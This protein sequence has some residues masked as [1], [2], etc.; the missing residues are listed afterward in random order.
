MT[1]LTPEQRAAAFAEDEAIAVIAGAGT[2][3]TRV[4][5]ERYLHLAVDRGVEL[6]RILTVTF[7]EKAAREMKDRIRAALVERGRTD[8]A[9]RAEFAPISTIHAFLSRVLRERALDAGIDPRA[10][11]ADEITADFFLDEAMAATVDGLDEDL[12][13]D[14]VE[15]TGSEE[16][17]RTLYLAARATPFEMAELRP[18]EPVREDLRARVAA[19]LDG[20]A[21]RTHPGATGGRLDGLHALRPRLLE[22]D[23]SAA[24]EFS[25][26]VKGR[27]ANAVRALF[28]DG[29]E[30]AE[31]YAGLAHADRA[32]RAGRAIREALCRLDAE[33]AER[34]WAEGIVD[35]ADLER[36]GLKLLRSP[37]AP[38]ILAEYDHLLVDEYQDTS[39][40]QEA[41]LE[42]LAK[43]C[44][45]FGVGDAKQSIY[46]FR[47][48]DAA[49]FTA[50]QERAR[51][52]PLAGSF[53][54]RPELVEFAN[55]LFEQLFLGSGVESQD[56][57][58]AAEWR[59][60][61]APCV[62][63]LTFP[64]D[65]A[66]QGRRREARALARR[67]RELVGERELE[68]TS[69]RDP[70]RP[71]GYRDCAILLRTMSNL[72]VY[73]RALAEEGV[74]YVVVKGRGYYAAREVVDLAH[75]L[76]ALA[77]PSDRYRA[78]GAMTSLLCG[79]PESDLLQLPE[80]GP[81][82]LAVRKTERPSAIPA[83]R[84]RRLQRFADQFERWRRRMGEVET[85][86]LIETILAE[87]RFADLVLAE[88]GG[89]RRRA[90]LLKVL[91][92][93]RQTHD[94]PVAY[95]R[96][97]LEFR[98]REVRESEAPIA[99]ETDEAVRIMTVHGAKGLEFP[100]VAVA[101]LTGAPPPRRGP[102]L[103]ADGV[104]GFRLLGENGSVKTAG[105]V[106]LDEWDKAQEE[107]EKLRLLY[108]ALTRAEEHLLLSGSRYPR[109]ADPFLE[110]LAKQRPP[111]VA[112]VD[113][114]RL[115]SAARGG[116]AQAGVR[117]AVR[118]GADLPADVPRDRAAARA[119][120]DR[121]E[122]I[123]VREP[124]DTPYV[125]AAADLVEF[126][127]CPRRYRLKRQL[128]I[129][130]DPEGF[131][132]E[133]SDA[134]EHPRRL[135]GTAFH[136]VMREV[137]PG[138]VPDEAAIRRHLP[139][140]RPKDL[141]KI[142]EWAKW[143]AGLDLV[144]GLAD[145]KTHC[146]MPFLTRI[147]DL[148]V[149]G[150][151]DLYVPSRPLLLDYKTGA[152]VQ[153]EEYGVQVAIYLAAVRSLGFEAPA[154]AHLVYVD[155]KTVVEVAEQP[156]DGLIGRFVAAHRKGEFAPVPS[157]ACV[158]CEFRKA[159]VKNGVPCPAGYALF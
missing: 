40:I 132:S 106:A 14:L 127:R 126:A 3:K 102:V 134:E 15:V 143:L 105:G 148:P 104:F 63:V 12:R 121:I 135:L 99:A 25:A 111:H 112:I 94:D 16:T 144:A 140:A 49:V 50:Y 6:E 90:N 79:V 87:T 44:R 107:C 82:P 37:A 84:W 108:V 60:K 96:A 55:G 113:C 145:V 98:E 74:P 57:E 130:L 61:D 35:F 118:R 128:G 46:R 22:L 41:I 65:G 137:G 70:E 33:Y 100:V 18:V 150:V 83:P 155:A 133:P 48:A 89:R 29:R 129:E 117:A 1:V 52:Y 77:D 5:T 153:A 131:E 152:R 34:K 141:R 17:L 43:R 64:A 75:L 54:S 116:R 78:V 110:R 146:E 95:A 8:L 36:C 69:A 73:E 120:L 72:S 67:L 91:R 53:R 9:R 24:E 62:E 114:D 58:A 19:F 115:G 154:A 45:R 51:C 159:C 109:A 32:R 97:L 42:E 23:P 81:L 20:C 27:V 156:V 122:T 125:A 13:A 103:D 28:A 66:A 68:R 71:L 31:E 2:G 139:A 124:D 7:T 149:R 136:E 157:D 119:L 11:V 56:L 21:G 76:L 85:G 80:E 158:H 86:D 93:A 151:I 142:R 4:L 88:P 30:L 59:A 123:E 10:V 39:R 92:R 38:A 147:A 26:L 138:A 101:D 47:Y